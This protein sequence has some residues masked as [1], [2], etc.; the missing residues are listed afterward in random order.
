LA[1]LVPVTEEIFFRGILLHRCAEK[2][3]WRPAIIILALIFGLLHMAHLGLFVFALLMT[4]FY[5]ETRSLW[6]PIL[7]HAL[8]NLVASAMIW[9]QGRQAKVMDYD[10]VLA[11]YQAHSTLGF[12]FFAGSTPLLL[13][14]I[15]SRWP[16]G[17]LRLPYAVNRAP[18]VARAGRSGRAS[19]P[20]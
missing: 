5:L 17:K 10:S 20:V 14:Y 13:W 12:L 6:V 8:N 19:V 16:S 11:F 18:R 2:W 7:C 3:G 15:H 4:L 9:A 1:G